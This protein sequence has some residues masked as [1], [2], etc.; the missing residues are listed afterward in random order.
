M[1]VKKVKKPVAATVEIERNKTVVDTKV[2]PMGVVDLTSST[3]NVGFTAA[4][5]KNL[6]NYESLKITVALYMPVPLLPP[7]SPDLVLDKAFEYV[8]NWV[9]AKINAV[10]AELDE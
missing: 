5:T 10:L 2:V 4:Y 3:A 7:Q 8:Q 6:G 9:D 1:G